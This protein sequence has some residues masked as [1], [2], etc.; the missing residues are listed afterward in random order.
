MLVN[1]YLKMLFNE[2]L[3]TLV[4][5]TCVE[6]TRAVERPEQRRVLPAPLLQ[7]HR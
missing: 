7:V 6:V 3:K 1:E 4:N 5:Q 2:N